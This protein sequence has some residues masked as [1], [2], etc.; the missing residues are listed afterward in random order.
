MARARWCGEEIYDAV[1][2][3]LTR[4]LVEDSSLFTPS[5]ELW[6]PNAVARVVEVVGV[7]DSESGSFIEK[8]ETQLS[9]LSDRHTQI[10][11]EPVSYTHLT[12]PTICSV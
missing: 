10:G 3:F 12:L 4:C 7:E 5:E 8:L 2:A 9:G 11:T 6:T 1:D